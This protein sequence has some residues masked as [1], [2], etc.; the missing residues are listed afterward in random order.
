VELARVNSA[1]ELAGVRFASLK[2]F[3]LFPKY[4]PDPCRRL[5]LD[6]DY[7][8]ERRQMTCVSGAVQKLGYQV[9]SD[10]PF[11]K[12]FATNP[13]ITRKHA[14]LYKP[15]ESYILEFHFSLFDRPELNVNSPGDALEHVR[16]VTLFGQSVSVLAEED[17]F[18]HQISH[19]FQ[20][21]FLFS[22]RL[23]SLLEISRA[24]RFQYD[25]QV[26]WNKVRGRAETWDGPMGPLIGLVLALAKSSFDCEVPPALAAWTTDRCA[27]AVSLWVN[28]YGRQWAL[29]AFPGNKLSL[30]VARE[31]MTLENWRDY[32]WKSL[33]PYPRH[34]EPG[35]T[36]RKVKRSKGNCRHKISRAIFH[37]REALRVA[38][39]WPRWRWMLRR[40]CMD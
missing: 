34:F 37:M 6:M 31:F 27:P 3:T 20:D 32:A 26:F 38:L 10:L 25:N 29:Q 2:G 40:S 11:E 30:L 1:L 7:L 14:D 13:E 15:P 19:V 16:R 36:A 33:L 12:R 9:V 18:L 4:C 21:V 8:V 28:R 39:E 23:S 24:I 22:L 5:Q 35:E 17:I